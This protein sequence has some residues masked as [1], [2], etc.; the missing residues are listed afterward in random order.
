MFNSCRKIYLFLSILSDSKISNFNISIQY[1][2]LAPSSNFSL[3]KLGGIHLLQNKRRV[4][5]KTFLISFLYL[6]I[7]L[8]IV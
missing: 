8:L 7:P 2:N 3:K 5:A 4:S 1:L 6:I